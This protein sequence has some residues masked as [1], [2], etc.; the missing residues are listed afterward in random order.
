M[1]DIIPTPYLTQVCQL[2]LESS[3][4]TAVDRTIQL[5]SV[6][7]TPKINLESEAF[8]AAGS[9]LTDIVV[10]GLENAE[11]S[12]DGW[13]TY[14]ELEYFVRDILKAAETDIPSYTYQIG[15][16]AVSEIYKGCIVDS[17]TLRGD[18]KGVKLSGNMFA[19]SHEAGVSD[20]AELT[21]VT[22]IPM[23]NPHVGT[24]GGFIKLGGTSLA[25]AFE[26]EL[27]MSNLWVGTQY[28]GANVFGGANEGDIEGNFSVKLEADATNKALLNTRTEQTLEVYLTNGTKKSR[29]KCNVQLSGVDAFEAQGQVYAYGLQMSVK[30][31]EV[32]GTGKV[33]TIAKA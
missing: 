16:G 21:P 30:N 2:G 23:E 11:I 10:Y 20:M 15:S 6:Q 19:A 12:F 4:G 18:T 17:W 5:A 29:L 27:S 3:Y 8:K 32:A 14:D 7:T 28:I 1:A 22:P 31:T 25:K 13:A 9:K 24:S 33:F 26:W